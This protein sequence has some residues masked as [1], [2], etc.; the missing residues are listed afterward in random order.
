M[1][2]DLL[3][4]SRHSAPASIHL[5]YAALPGLRASKT[6]AV[7]PAP[8]LK[9]LATKSCIKNVQSRSYLRLRL[10]PTLLTHLGIT[11]VGRFEYWQISHIL[12]RVNSPAQLHEIEENSPQIKGEDAELWHAFI[13]KHVPDWRRKSYQPKNPAKWYEVYEKYKREQARELEHDTA[14]LKEKMMGLQ[15]ARETNVSK[16]MD[17]KELPKMPR[18]PRMLA[19]NGGVPIGKSRGFRKDAPSSLTWNTGSKT[20]LTN[21]KSVL[22]RARREAAEIG[23]RS[24]L[25]K[26]TSMLSGKPSQVQ[27]APAG[28]LRERAI[29]SQPD[30]KVLASRKTELSY[31]G[32]VRGPDLEE[33]ENRLRKLTMGGPGAK[34]TL[35]GSSDE[36]DD[37]L[38][39]YDMPSKYRPQVS[40]TSRSIRAPSRPWK[41]QCEEDNEDDLFG[42]E[43]RPAKSRLTSSSRPSPASSSHSR[44]TPFSSSKQS[45][46]S[47]SSSSAQKPSDLIS[48]ILGN[49]RS[50]A[51]GSSEL[52]PP[53]P[54]ASPPR[55]KPMMVRKKA[56]VDCFN[57]G[58]KR[59][60]RV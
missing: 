31:E 30:V 51:H 32:G 8:S 33:R 20:K 6:Y 50:R 58:A 42:E 38:G 55:E 2:T 15:K 17:R 45:Q 36:E 53:P 23:M 22:T 10:R 1:R 5:S 14:V 11:D 18:D 46:S 40:S 39:V 35:V 47:T 21:G 28:M 37:D 3:S 19:N 49:T 44:P 25:T 12:A 57:R 29:A 13:A 52:S 7:M 54:S 16:L 4:I 24:R 26:P 60:R 43:A 56:P 48:S 34:S 9:M 27:Q 59:V 41:R